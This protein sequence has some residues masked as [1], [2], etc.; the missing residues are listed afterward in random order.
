MT[1]THR[2]FMLKVLLTLYFLSSPGA[3]GPE[4][5]AGSRKGEA[6]SRAGTLQE[7]LDAATDPTLAQRQPLQG[8]SSQV[9]PTRQPNCPEAHGHQPLSLFY[10]AWSSWLHGKDWL[11]P[12]NEWMNREGWAVHQVAAH[13]RLCRGPPTRANVANP[14]DLWEYGAGTHT[15]T[16]THL[17]FTVFSPCCSY[18]RPL[19]PSTPQTKRQSCQWGRSY[20]R[21]GVVKGTGTL[22]KLLASLDR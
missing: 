11:A 18:V 15:R 2:S 6:P 13:R 10:M 21:R 22:Q 7:V 17:L 4:T 16:R 19:P 9:T 12:W 14:Q 5:E 1:C 8:L 20:Y 3:D